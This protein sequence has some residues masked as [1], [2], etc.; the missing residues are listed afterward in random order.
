MNSRFFIHIS[1]LLAAVTL[2]ACS[3][4]DD[5]SALGGQPL[6]LY[7]DM[8]M[9]RSTVD[10][11]WNVGDE[12]A[13]KIGD[14]IKIYYIKDAKTGELTTFGSSDPFRWSPNF[15]SV[16]VTAW[17]LGGFTNAV[18]LT[19]ITIPKD[20]SPENV[21]YTRHDLLY[22][23]GTLTPSN[24]RLTFYHQMARV[25][26]QLEFK[27]AVEPNNVVSVYLGYD[28]DA[29]GNLIDIVPLT[30]E[31]SA[32]TGNDNYGTWENF[33][34]YPNGGVTM[35]HDAT[36]EDGLSAT[37]SALLIPKDYSGT[38]FICIDTH[39]NLGLFY[40]VPSDGEADL[41]S[42]STYTYRI[43]VNNE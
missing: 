3:S 31:F 20:Q 6:V 25:I 41:Q 30:G 27:T 42:G 43:T 13:V 26:V 24:T 37:F 2:L 17:S 11:Q 23:K 5:V 40:F 28:H 19:G 32:P 34:N 18:P 4:E 36:A 14:E 33:S 15:D 1:L 8:P 16:E 12:V 35:F 22:A 10:N 21:G 29:E 38:R 7:A 9:T 39:T